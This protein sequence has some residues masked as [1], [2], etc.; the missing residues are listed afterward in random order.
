VAR[1]Q[2]PS[3]TLF[4][5]QR[6]RMA[7]LLAANGAAMTPA[8]AGVP[9]GATHG[10]FDGH[11]AVRDGGVQQR[12]ERRRGS[13]S[14]I[15]APLS[16]SRSPAALGLA[17]YASPQTQAVAHGRAGSGSALEVNE[18]SGGLRLQTLQP[19]SGRVATELVVEGDGDGNG[20]GD[21]DVTDTP[22]RHPRDEWEGSGAL[23]LSPHRFGR[24]DDAEDGALRSAARAGRRRSTL[25]LTSPATA[26]ASQ[27]MKRNS[28]V[29]TAGLL[30][31]LRP[32]HSKAAPVALSPAQLAAAASGTMRKPATL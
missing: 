18:G 22:P 16:V 8:A 1:P 20:D 31:Q 5:Q 6:S 15:S 19:S 10:S 14:A 11:T 27:S 30:A 7:T 4:A 9:A 28:S 3:K 25:L 29:A 2:Q 32:L 23:A 26:A 24:D 12:N 17:S 21:R 13:R